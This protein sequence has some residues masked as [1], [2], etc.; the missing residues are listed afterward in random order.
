MSSTQ[1]ERPSEMKALHY[2][3][4]FKVS[5]KTIPTP[6]LEHPDDVLVKV[7]TACI[8]GSDLHMYGNLIFIS[9]EHLC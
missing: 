8:C 4:P 5:I 2:D 1:T 3:A 6:K 7:T 9:S